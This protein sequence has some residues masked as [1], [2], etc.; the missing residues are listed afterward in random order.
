M[1]YRRENPRD[2]TGGYGDVGPFRRDIKRPTL[3]RVLQAE[4]TVCVKVLENL[5]EVSR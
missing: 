3:G 2:M 1:F 5:W 4:E